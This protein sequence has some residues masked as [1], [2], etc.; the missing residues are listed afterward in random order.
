[1]IRERFELDGTTALVVGGRGLLGTLIA[2]ALNELGAPV[3]FLASD[4]ASY[5]TGHNLGVD[6]AWTI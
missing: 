6:G 2:A 3:V 5:I 1:M 4:A